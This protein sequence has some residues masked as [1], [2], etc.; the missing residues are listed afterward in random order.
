MI[1]AALFLKYQPDFLWAFAGK[2][3]V[4]IEKGCRAVKRTRQ[5]YNKL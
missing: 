5:N 2:V 3:T 4:S 1:K